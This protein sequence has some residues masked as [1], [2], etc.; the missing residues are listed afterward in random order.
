MKHKHNISSE[1]SISY[2]TTNKRLTIIA[3]LGVTIGLAIFVFMNSMMK[4]F[5][6][7][8]TEAIF[9]TVSHIRLFKDDETSK[10]LV[11]NANKEICKK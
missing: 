3:A 9:K 5:D 7:I 2:I 11:N 8:S 10:P 4:G 1:I 6:R